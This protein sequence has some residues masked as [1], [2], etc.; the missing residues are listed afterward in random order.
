LQLGK[1]FIFSGD[2][3]I[4]DETNGADVNEMIYHETNGAVSD[5]EM[6]YDETNDALSVSDETIDCELKKKFV[7]FSSKDVL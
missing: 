1:I 4:Y 3:T 7:Y 2:E 5:C 6:I